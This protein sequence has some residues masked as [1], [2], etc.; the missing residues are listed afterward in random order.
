MIIEN[1]NSFVRQIED[2]DIESTAF[3]DVYSGTVEG[4][5]TIITHVIEVSRISTGDS[6]KV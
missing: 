1:K 6:D 5:I 4:R 2:M 3:T